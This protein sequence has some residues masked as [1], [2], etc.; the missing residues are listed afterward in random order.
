VEFRSVSAFT[1]VEAQYRDMSASSNPRFR[2]DRLRRR[3]VW[4]APV[5]V[6]G[7]VAAGLVLSNASAD[8]AV[9]TLP[10]RTPA[11][12]LT[13]VLSSDG[14][15]LSGE[16]KETANLGLPSLPGGHSSASLSWQ[17]FVT[18]SHSARV[19]VDGSDKQRIALLGELSEAD[20]VHNGSDVWTYTSDTNTVTHSTL[21]QPSKTDPSPS[22]ND[23]TPAGAAARALKAVGPSTSVTVGSATTVAGRSAYTLVIRPRDSRST[24]NKVTIAVD[25]TKSV[26][27]RVRVYGSSAT[28]AFQT[29]FTTVSFSTPAASTFAFHSPAGATTSND[30]LGTS[31]GRHHRSGRSHAPDSSGRATSVKPK[32]IGQNW[33]SVVELPAGRGLQALSVGGSTVRDLTTPVGSSG[34][35]LLHTALVN[36]VILPDGRTFI[37]AVDPSVLEHIAA[38]TPN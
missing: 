19:W 23:L 13:A 14:V 5:L 2:S 22:A 36:A 24:V 33:T 17:T 16:I 12:L 21:K 35:R 8:G 4:G 34:Q 10:T 32:V 31:G 1:A 37:G 20:V 15:A 11:Q 18:G 7:A 3:A 9:P 38:T 28:P 30:P 25:A 29:G 6:A 27:L 26:P